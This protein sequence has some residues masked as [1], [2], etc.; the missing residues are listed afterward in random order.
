VYAPVA[1]SVSLG[2]LG[3]VSLSNRS[4]V[5]DALLTPD[6]RIPWEAAIGCSVLG[7]AWSSRYLAAYVSGPTL[8]R[9]SHLTHS[10]APIGTCRGR[11]VIGQSSSRHE[12]DCGAL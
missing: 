1:S 12:R 4:L 9:A 6:E 8:P 7:R 11:R 2:K 10:P 3:T 5:S